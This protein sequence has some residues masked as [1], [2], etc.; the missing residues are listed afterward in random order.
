MLLVPIQS[1]FRVRCLIWGSK[2]YSKDENYVLSFVFR[3]ISAAIFSATTSGKNQL[4]S[5]NAIRFN[6]QTVLSGCPGGNRAKDEASAT[7]KPLT[8]LTRPLESTTAMGSDELPILPK[9]C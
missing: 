8:P 6:L 5:D 3:I 1:N 4:M 7:R 9:A 2:S